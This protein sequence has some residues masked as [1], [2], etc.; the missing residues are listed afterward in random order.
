MV[1]VV[2]ATVDHQRKK[3]IMELLTQKDRDKHLCGPEVGQQ[4]M[5]LTAS[6]CKECPDTSVYIFLLQGRD[7]THQYF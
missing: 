1:P 2:P 6:K 3:F 4:C 7:L 5:L